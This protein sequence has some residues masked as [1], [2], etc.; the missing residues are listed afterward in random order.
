MIVTVT[1]GRGFRDHRYVEFILDGMHEAERITILRHGGSNGVD[2]L[3]GGWAGDHFVPVQVFW[4]KW[5]SEGKSAGVRRNARMLDARPITDGLV[6]F[7]GG[8]GTANCVM[9]ARKRRIPVFDAGALYEEWQ[10]RPPSLGETV[11]E[12][13]RDLMDE[14]KAT[15]AFEGL[16]RLDLSG[17]RP[18]PP[19]IA[20]PRPEL[21]DLGL[22]PSEIDPEGPEDVM[23]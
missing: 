4:A 14:M 15:E 8:K 10:N 18:N 20:P 6:A 5:E 22:N 16:M 2:S 7:P 23:E 21:S 13:T 3:A 9:N 12:A 17:I 1:G 11:V 19:R